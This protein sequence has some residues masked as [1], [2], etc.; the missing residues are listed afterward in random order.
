[1]NEMA[2]RLHKF[3]KASSAGVALAAAM[4]LHLFRINTVVFAQLAPP[5][6]ELREMDRIELHLEHNDARVDALQNT[7]SHLEGGAEVAFGLI[8][9]LNILG[10]IRFPKRQ[11]ASEPQPQQ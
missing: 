7:V 8:T 2:L 11:P 5:S 6:P 3:S 1:M 4:T 9:V 10:F